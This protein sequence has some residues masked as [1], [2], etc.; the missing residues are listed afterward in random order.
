[1]KNE[2]NEVFI[3]LKASAANE[4]AVALCQ[5]AGFSIEVWTVNTV[6]D[7]LALD[8]YITGI[9]SDWLYAADVID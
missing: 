9:A 6:A 1:M 5:N 7:A 8:S 3:D 2:K 4:D